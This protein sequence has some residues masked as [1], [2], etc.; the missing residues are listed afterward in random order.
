MR[1]LPCGNKMLPYFF[2]ERLKTDMK[3]YGAK[4]ITMVFTTIKKQGI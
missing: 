1:L 4:N 2:R 3:F